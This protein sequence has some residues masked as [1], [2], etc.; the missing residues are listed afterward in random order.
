MCDHVLAAAAVFR[1]AGFMAEVL[2]PSDRETVELGRSQTS[3]KECYPLILT[4]GD[5]LKLARRP[6]FNPERSAFF[7]P[8]ASGPCRFG[9]YG[10]YL[11]LLLERLGLGSVDVVSIDQAGGMYKDLDSGGGRGGRD[12][13][14]KIWSALA[15]ADFLQKARRQTRPRE[16]REGAADTAYRAA[17][18]DLVKT[19]EA[20]RDPV[21]VMTRARESFDAAEDRAAPAGAK[22]RVGLVGEIYVRQND[23][24]NEDI[25]RRLE[26]LGVEVMAPPFTEW[27]LYLNF[28]MA[29]RAR[30]VGDWKKRLAAGA[31]GWAQRREM[32]RL[33]A[34]WRGFFHF[35]AVDPPIAEVIGFGEKFIHRSFQGEAILSLGKGMEFFHHQAAGLVNIMPFTCMPGMVVGGLT[36]S[37]RAAAGGLPS[38]NLSFDGQSQTNTQ[39]RLEAFIGQAKSFHARSAGRA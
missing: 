23:F 8:S 31:V 9:Q 3:G 29:M 5:F 7:M 17:L 35:G 21:Q 11:R 22:P 38:L 20:G 25:V 14:R 13:S 2:P 32:K 34:P 24:A 12:L 36:Q 33:A 16:N 1:N 28:L 27:V 15:A 37:F 39:A 10:R 30:R 18:V 4:V 19:L 26:D 6:G